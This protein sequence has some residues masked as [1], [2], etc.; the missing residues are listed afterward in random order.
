M[1]VL[2]M[3][4]VVE[5]IKLTEYEKFSLD[6]EANS[7]EYFL[8]KGEIDHAYLFQKNEAF[9]FWLIRNNSHRLYNAPYSNNLK[10]NWP[11]FKINGAEMEL[12]LSEGELQEPYNFDHEVFLTTV[13][14]IYASNFE[15]IVEPVYKC[16]DYTNWFIYSGFIIILTVLII[17]KHESITT[18]LGPLIP[19]FIRWSRE[20]LPS[21]QE[22]VSSD[23][24]RD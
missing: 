24:E 18:I 11:E 6:L 7:S 1:F 13:Y 12:V 2:L 9:Q 17:F 23:E 14:S 21:G 22:E 10:F 16:M 3:L 19:W 15:Y 4:C 20:I 5:A 8:F